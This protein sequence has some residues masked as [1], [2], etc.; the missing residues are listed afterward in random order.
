M[1]ELCR[2]H[3]NVQK[4]T[5]S[6]VFRFSHH[7]FTKRVPVTGIWFNLKKPSSLFTFKFLWVFFV[8]S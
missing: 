5:V 6:A 4:F 7:T 3:M 1:E 8:H 2:L